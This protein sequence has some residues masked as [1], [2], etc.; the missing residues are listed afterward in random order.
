MGSTDWTYLNDGLDIAAV[1]RG[2]TA[3]AF[4][5]GFLVS[6]VL[7]PTLGR[8][9]D[10]RGPRTVML[11]RLQVPSGLK[12]F[13]AGPA[14][15]TT[16]PAGSVVGIGVTYAVLSSYG[17]GAAPIA[18]AAVLSGW[19]NT[20]V[21]F[22]LPSGA[23]LILALR[24][25]SNRLLVS[26]AAVGLAL[27]AAAIVVLVLV[28]TRERFARAVGRTA[29]RVVSWLRRLVRRDPVVGWDEGFARFPFTSTEPAS[30]NFSAKEREGAKDPF[31]RK[32]SNLV[33]E[34]SEAAV[35]SRNITPWPSSSPA[36]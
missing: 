35:A 3:G 22:G 36:R 31:A 28:S 13:S 21:V 7:S 29:G 18:L 6:A 23:A 33:P 12:T 5:F 26:G 16:V 19:W 32:V 11:P 24:G 10:S 15:A 1:D 27:L 20:L 9:M 4:S 25:G 30:I 2:V 8:L 34:S 14:I 17:H